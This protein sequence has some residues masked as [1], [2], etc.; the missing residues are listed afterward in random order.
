MAV[1]L[2]FHFSV[3]TRERSR[4]GV[5][6]QPASAAV[7]VVVILDGPKHAE[8][9]KIFQRI[10]ND[11]RPAAF[12]GLLITRREIISDFEMHGQKK[13]VECERFSLL[14]GIVFVDIKY[15]ITFN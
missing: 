5:P 10:R 3:R 9:Y 14:F 12:I 13:L 6:W 4:V 11:V 8:A 2:Q 1:S 7:E 15:C